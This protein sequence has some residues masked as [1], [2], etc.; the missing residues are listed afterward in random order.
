MSCLVLISPETFLQQLTICFA[1]RGIPVLLYQRLVSDFFETISSLFPA[2]RRISCISRF[3]FRVLGAQFNVLQVFFRVV[4]SMNLGQ[5]SPSQ[6]TMKTLSRRNLEEAHVNEHFHFLEHF[7]DAFRPPLLYELFLQDF[8][9]SI[10]ALHC[11]NNFFHYP[12]SLDKPFEGSAKHL[13]DIL[14][15]SEP[16]AFAIPLGELLHPP[17]PLLSEYCSP[18]VLEEE[19]DEL[20]QIDRH[21]TFE[22]HAH[23]IGLL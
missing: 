4:I 16:D 11:L 6:E 8:F 2:Q 1:L 14:D 17:Q 19:S 21:T 18:L 20:E 22:A 3:T 23:V 15:L 10:I 7:K 9:Y 13:R 5:R 12:D